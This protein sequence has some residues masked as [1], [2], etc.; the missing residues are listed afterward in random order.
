MMIN[1]GTL[2]V[3]VLVATLVAVATICGLGRQAPRRAAGSEPPPP[4]PTNG[5]RD[6]SR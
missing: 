3:L 2:T 5:F 1:A 6:P 4:N